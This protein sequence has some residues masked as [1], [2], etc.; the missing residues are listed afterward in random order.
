MLFALKEITVRYFSICCY[1]RSLFHAHQGR[2]SLTWKH[3]RD[4]KKCPSAKR[5]WSEER[6]FALQPH[7]VLHIP[8]SD[9]LTAGSDIVERQK[10]IPQAILVFLMEKLDAADERVIRKISLSF[11]VKASKM[12]CTFWLVHQHCEGVC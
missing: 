12:R 9:Q 6:S 5:V 11:S 10:A 8:H 4:T 2:W 1:K 7:H 3:E